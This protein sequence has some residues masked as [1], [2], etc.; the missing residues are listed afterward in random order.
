MLL[1][2]TGKLN[3]WL[4][5]AVRGLLLRPLRERLCELLEETEKTRQRQVQSDAA[6]GQTTNNLE[7]YCRGCSLN[8]SCRYGRVLEP[9]REGL[10]AEEQNKMEGAEEGRGRAGAREGLRGL[11]IAPVFPAP[12]TAT[13]GQ[14]LR[15]RVLGLGSENKGL[16]RDA[17]HVLHQQGQQAGLGPDRVKLQLQPNSLQ[18]QQSVISASELPTEPGSGVVPSVRLHL[19]TPLLLRESKDKTGK[20]TGARGRRYLT[21]IEPADSLPTLLRDSIRTVRRALEEYGSTRQ[22]FDFDPGPLLAAAAEVPCERFEWETIKQQRFSARRD[23]RWEVTG[24]Q[25]Y[26]TYRN[27]PVGILPWLIW[28]GRL[29]VGDSRNCGG[30][31]WHLVLL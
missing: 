7:L 1:T 26:A 17:L 10:R 22:W 13:V 23:Q 20:R 27:V 21:Q 29:G 3:T 8:Q 4:G 18:L 31:L 11:T 16:M 28:G 9:Y 15:L 24:W 19:E 6:L 25:G 30:G 14:I 5:P 2:S 12:E